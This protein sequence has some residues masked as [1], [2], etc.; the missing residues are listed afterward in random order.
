MPPPSNSYKWWV[1]GMLWL[2]CLFNYAD[3]QAVFSVFDPIKE[4][5]TLEDW[6]LGVVGSSFMWVY[7]ITLP[8]AGLVVDRVSRKALILGGL[9]FW[10]AVTLATAFAQNY[11][12]LVLCRAL[13]GFGE[14]FYFPASMSLVSDYH[15]KAARSKAM[16]FHQSSV[17][18]GTVAGGVV[19]GYFGQYYG[20]RSGF[21]LFGVAG[22]VLAAVLVFTLREPPRG[23]ADDAD[24]HARPPTPGDLA[25]GAGEVLRTPMALVLLGVFVGTVFVGSLFLA[26]TPTYLKR[27]F[28]LDLKTAGREATLWLTLGS[29][30][31]VLAGG[32]LADRLAGRVRGGR[33]W[34]QAA[35]LFA[36]A[37]LLLAAGGAGS[38][39]GFLVLLALFGFCKGL[40]DSNTWAALYDVVRPER[41]GTALGLVNGLGWLLGGA[42]APVAY[43]LLAERYGAGPTISATSGIYLLTGILLVIGIWFILPRRPD[44][45]TPSE[46]DTP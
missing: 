40:Y 13:E 36:G 27:E 24:P 23:A 31:G 1:V 29:V 33:M 25:R 45:R 2:V 39:G 15:G 9:A 17:Y 21:Y 11:W 46:D 41:R 7:A 43:A 22:L 28:G 20:W 26:W 32:W 5:M 38:L 14:A 12:Q 8:F 6:Q 19:A 16:A 42:T 35:G 44:D 37:P 18:A 10:S 4:E 30:L 34:V 3:R